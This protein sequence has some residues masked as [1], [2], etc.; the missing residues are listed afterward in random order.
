MS[1]PRLITAETKRAA[2]H[3][4]DYQGRHLR[5]DLWA[6]CEGRKPAMDRRPAQRDSQQPT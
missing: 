1:G 5:G 3:F 6:E 2:A 4:V